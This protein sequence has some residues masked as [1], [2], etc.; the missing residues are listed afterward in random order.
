M[1]CFRK[2][3][4]LG[5]QLE[6]NSTKASFTCHIKTRFLECEDSKSVDNYL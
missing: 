5:S 3:V 6:C 1:E 2:I 4:S